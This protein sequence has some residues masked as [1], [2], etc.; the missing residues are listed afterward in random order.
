MTKLYYTAPTDE[1]FE[2]LKRESIKLWNTYDNTYGYVDEKVG[3]IEG[4]ENI[5]DNFMF[6]FAMF[7]HINMAKIVRELSTETKHELRIR[8]IDG[9]SDPTLYG[10]EY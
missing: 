1:A 7:D 8:I 9:G 3:R 6:M 4:M 5:R 10:F 2:E